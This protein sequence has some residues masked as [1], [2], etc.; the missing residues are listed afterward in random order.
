[1]KKRQSKRARKRVLYSVLK[2]TGIVVV[3][4]VVGLSVLGLE[5]YSAIASEVLPRF[6]LSAA[7]EVE[8]SPVQRVHH[9]AMTIVGGRSTIP[10]LAQ[11][12]LVEM[13]LLAKGAEPSVVLRLQKNGRNQPV[14]EYERAVSEAYFSQIWQ[15]LR[16]LEIAQLTDLSPYTEKVMTSKPV[17]SSLT[18]APKASATYRFQFKDGLYDYPN[19]FEVHAPEQLEDFRYEG[20]R[21]LGFSVLA[22]SFSDVLTQQ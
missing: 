5:R 16:D 2:A 22:D 17:S 14:Q 10:G 8:A 1:M 11:Y 6:N 13:E 12:Q 3:S 9:F 18:A 15:N 7:A 20:V 19:S 4:G 21:D